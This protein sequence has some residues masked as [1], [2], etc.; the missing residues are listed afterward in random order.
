MICS[1][2][3]LSLDY[4]DQMT[5]KALCA[6]N[7]L[8]TLLV[9]KSGNAVSDVNKYI[10]SSEKVEFVNVDERPA[11]LNNLKDSDILVTKLTLESWIIMATRLFIFK[12]K[13]MVHALIRDYMIIYFH[14][15]LSKSCNLGKIIEEK[16]TFLGCYMIN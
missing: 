12:K 7:F 11:R 1:L 16:Q 2:P 14:K 3:I 5:I 8:W 9:N 10:F 4:C 13:C 6:R 15:I